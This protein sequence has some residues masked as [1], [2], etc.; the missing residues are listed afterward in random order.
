MG[1]VPVILVM[2]IV[3]ALL[4]FLSFTIIKP[5]YE[6]RLE[7]LEKA[8]KEAEQQEEDRIKTLVGR[9]FSVEATNKDGTPNDMETSLIGCM[10]DRGIEV[11]GKN[12]PEAGTLR[13]C[14]IR[15]P[16]DGYY[17]VR[18][19]DADNIKAARH[20]SGDSDSMSST[21]RR[22]LLYLGERMGQQKK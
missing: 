20:F 18:G 5:R 6:R 4:F 7:R 21:A 15:D 1:S 9:T 14:I 12:P 3:G 16:V 22:I 10:V 13:I 17:D 11:S 19:H 2:A 8:E